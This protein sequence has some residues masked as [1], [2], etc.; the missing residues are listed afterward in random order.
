MGCCLQQGRN[1]HHKLAILLALVKLD[2]AQKHTQ[3]PWS[4]CALLADVLRPRAMLLHRRRDDLKHRVGKR[5]ARKLA[6][7]APVPVLVVSGSSRAL[8]PFWIAGS[9]MRCDIWVGIF[10]SRH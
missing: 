5:P 1:T 9:G 2:N 4:L 6:C 3:R 7:T 10:A 8:E